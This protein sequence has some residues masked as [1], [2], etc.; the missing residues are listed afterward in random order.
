MIKKLIII[1]VLI[2]SVSVSQTALTKD[3]FFPKR[4]LFPS[5]YKS[6]I[7]DSRWQCLGSYKIRN[8]RI[9]VPDSLKAGK[10]FLFDNGKTY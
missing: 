4:K 1:F 2:S 10:I 9:T 3:A 7:I 5:N 6:I 8:N